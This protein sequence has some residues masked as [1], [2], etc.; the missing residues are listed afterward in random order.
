MVPTQ[1]GELLVEV[2]GVRALRGPPRAR[3]RLPCWFAVVVSV[4]LSRSDHSSVTGQPRGASTSTTSVSPAL[5]FDVPWIDRPPP[6]PYFPAPVP[7][8]A[9]PAD[10]P[11]CLADDVSIVANGTNG[12][13]GLDFQYFGVKN[14]G[15]TT[16]LLGGYPPRVV[17]TEPRQ[18]D[19]VAR[20]GVA[21]G[22]PGP[23]ANVA[24]DQAGELFLQTSSRCLSG[25]GPPPS[26]HTLLVT[27]PG[28]GTVTVHGTFGVS[29]GL[30][31]SRFGVPQPEPVYP[32]QWYQSVKATMQAPTT[33]D[34]GTTLT[35]VV[36]LTNDTAKALNIDHC[37]GYYERGDDGPVEAT[38]DFSLNCDTEHRISAHRRLRYQMKLEIPADAPTGPMTVQWTIDVP[39]ATPVTAHAGVQGTR[40]RPSLPHRSSHGHRNRPRLPIQRIRHLLR[41]RRRDNTRH[42]R[43]QHVVDELH[44]SRFTRSPDPFGP[45]EP[46]SDS[47]TSPTAS[48]SDRR[49]HPDLRV[50]LAPGQSATSTL[51]WHTRWCAT[52]PNPVH[53]ELTLPTNSN[54]V[55]VNPT[56]GWTPPACDGFAWNSVSS[57]PFH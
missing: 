49:H 14:V 29:C 24:P 55:T 8:T 41:Q 48:A 12:A 17:A 32:P 38:G 2:C 56:D 15:S 36:T 43:H 30:Q 45:R 4:L 25:Q 51:A 3:R 33:V 47:N 42:Y 7:T 19:V 54:V 13:G 5:A 6:P 39:M 40:Q 28:G 27:L 22:D 44:T 50:T 34:A 10:A 16:C 20:D 18:P 57:E 9:P 26:Y 37:V 1:S 46:T 23:S 31:T 35:Y 21:P 52:N 11:L 53:V